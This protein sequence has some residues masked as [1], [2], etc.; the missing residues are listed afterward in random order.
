MKILFFLIVLLHGLIHLLGFVKGFGLKEVKEL[1]LPISKPMGLFWMFSFLL[2]VLYG[3]L[4]F[5]NNR[6]LWL[7]GCIAAVMSQILI[8]MYWKDAKFG[9]IPNVLIFLVSIVG[10]GSFL[11][12]NEFSHRVKEDF[13]HN[14]QKETNTLTQ[15]D[16]NHLPEMVQKYLHYTKSVG[17]PKVKNFRAEFTG[18]MRSKPEDDYMS[19]RSVQYNF[20]QKP[21]R[22]FFME[23]KKMGLP[24]TGL[25]LYQNET[26]TFEVRMLNWFKVV[27]AKGDKMNQAETVTLFNDM[28]FIAPATLIDRNIT[29]ET[30]DETTVK[31]VFKNGNQ[32][33]S[34][35]LYFKQNGELINFISN[36][37]YDTDGKTYHN[38]PWATPVEDYKMINGYYLPGKAKLIYQKPEGD[39]TYGEL[40]YLSVSYNLSELME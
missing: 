35:I 14:N 18:G 37:R 13:F 15:N 38:H 6:Y 28:C 33:I 1:S 26:A 5:S 31:G 34:A 21:S 12:K 22:Y 40:E 4:Q 11:L 25:H 24:A 23:A 3:L 8:F 17:Q 32:Q 29:W 2:F 30:I 10:L 36:D 16:I 9:T 39:F 20:F 27:D 19:L 7:F